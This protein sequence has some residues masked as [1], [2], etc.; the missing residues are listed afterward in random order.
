MLRLLE[1]GDF[2]PIYDRGGID[3]SRIIKEAI[4]QINLQTYFFNTFVFV[5]VANRGFYAGFDKGHFEPIDDFGKNNTVKYYQ[6]LPYTTWFPFDTNISPFYE[7]AF[8]YQIVGALF[9]GLIIG[10]CDSFICGFMIHVK[11]QLRILKSNLQ[12]YVEKAK[13]KIQVCIQLT[14]I[15]VTDMTENIGS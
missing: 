8:A 4:R 11:A 15:S 1:S 2:L 6:L 12:S 9:G 13:R 3:E 10:T 7:I 14:Q 5:T